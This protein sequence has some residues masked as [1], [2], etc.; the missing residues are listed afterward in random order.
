MCVKAIIWVNVETSPKNSRWNKPMCKIV[1]KIRS[2]LL[3][4]STMLV[5]MLEKERWEWGH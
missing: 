3:K 2:S 4:M 5:A 1:D